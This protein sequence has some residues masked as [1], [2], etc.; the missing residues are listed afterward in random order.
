MLRL[1]NWTMISG[2]DISMISLNFN[3]HLCENSYF[4]ILS[5]QLSKYPINK[6]I[7]IYCIQ[8]YRQNTCEY[9]NLFY[10]I[11]PINQFTNI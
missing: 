4:D 1:L 11:N 5:Y 9:L 6:I 10:R 3:I 7:L 8:C 2:I